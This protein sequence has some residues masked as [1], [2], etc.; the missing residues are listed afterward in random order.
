MIGT[1]SATTLTPASLSQVWASGVTASRTTEHLLY[2][3]D[4]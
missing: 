1:G 3:L 2:G 4:V